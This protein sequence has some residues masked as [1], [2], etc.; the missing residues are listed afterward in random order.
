LARDV[1]GWRGLPCCPGFQTFSLVTSHP[2]FDVCRLR[3][4]R[5]DAPKPTIPNCVVPYSSIFIDPILR[6]QVQSMA[7]ERQR[8][9][10]GAA[11]ASN[12]ESF[13]KRSKRA[14]GGKN[15]TFLQHVPKN[16]EG[17]VT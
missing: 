8:A 5:Q 17:K 11:D 6:G 16:S 1:P 10:A 15:F 13:W 9:E 14:L 2:H 12:P 3:A 7:D 4:L